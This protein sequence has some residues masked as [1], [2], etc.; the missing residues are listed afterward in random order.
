MW[1]SP[2]GEQRFR[3]E[4]SPLYAYGVSYQDEIFAKKSADGTLVFDAIAKRGGHST[5]QIL[6]SPDKPRADF[7]RLWAKLQAI[8]CSYES[9]KDPENVFAVDVPPKADVYAVYAVLKDGQREGVWEFGEGHC[10]HPLKNNAK[11]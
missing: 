11:N 2:I 1:A 3:L 10:G 7:D 4:N 8:G 6:L 5:Y 9:S